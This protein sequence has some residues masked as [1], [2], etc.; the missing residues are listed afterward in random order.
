MLDAWLKKPKKDGSIGPAVSYYNQRPSRQ[1]KS[2]AVLHSAKQIRQ[3]LPGNIFAARLRSFDGDEN[4]IPAAVAKLRR[5]IAV[6]PGLIDGGEIPVDINHD[7]GR[8]RIVIRWAPEVDR[9]MIRL[10]AQVLSAW[11]SGGIFSFLLP[12]NLGGVG[13]AARCGHRDQSREKDDEDT[14]LHGVATEGRRV[15]SRW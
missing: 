15:T 10:D 13:Q 14:S 11:F 5:Q 6:R 12:R 2:D 3:R 8:A 4:R 7:A 9:A 1:G